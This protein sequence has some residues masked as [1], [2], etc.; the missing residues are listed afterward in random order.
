LNAGD[1]PTSVRHL[2]EIVALDPSHDG[3]LYMLGVAHALADDLDQALSYLQQAIAHNPDNLALALRDADL[4]RLMQDEAIRAALH[5]VTP[6][7]GETRTAPRHRP[8]R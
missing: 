6:R 3:A 1:R 4:E 7:A 8:I 5:G 2:R